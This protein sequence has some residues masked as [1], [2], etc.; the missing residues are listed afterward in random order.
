MKKLVTILLLIGFI[1]V[2]AGNRPVYAGEIDLLLQKLVEK[3][4]LT[5]GEAQQ[6][7]TETKE[8]IKAE[9]AQG[10]YSSL[11][12]WVQNMKMKGDFR[13]RYQLDHGKTSDA[14]VTS[15]RNRG[16][17]RLRLGW[18]TKVNDKIMVGAGIATGTTDYTSYD[19]ARS[20]NQ[21][22]EKGLAKKA[23]V[24]DY[25]YAKYSPFAWASLMGGK[26][27]YLPWRPTDVMIDN[28][29][30][31]EGA[32]LQLSKKLGKANLFLD[33]MAFVLT[34]TEP[35]THNAMVYGIQGG[36]D[37]ALTDNLSLKS[38]LS[39][40]DFS[41][42]KGRALDGSTG[43]NTRDPYQVPGSTAAK[44][45][46]YKYGYK[47][48][49]PAVELGIKNPLKAIANATGLSML[50]IE[51][52]SFFGEYYDNLAVHAKGT[53]FAGGFGFG[54]EKIDAWGKWQVQ[55]V[56]SMTEKDS[57]LDILPD[58]DRYVGTTGIRGHKGSFQ[59]GLGKN[60]WLQ[61]ALFRF[62]NINNSYS[63]FRRAPTTVMQVD[64]NMKF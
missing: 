44:S 3:G 61:C 31:P 17:V 24:L 18:D 5:A 43:T 47:I 38:A 8:Q 1:A 58:S 36:A 55:Y 40:Y 45:G 27:K 51:K 4:V 30:T 33:N 54:N 25:A 37:Y 9:I 20:N 11:P 19:A 52:L 60:T 12:E 48:V 63:T 26:M 53:G 57:I 29:I 42:V 10:K 28:D 35:T 56:Y 21:S 50:D 64:W 41:N 62:E 13:V 23:L 15:D 34:E 6:I 46:L 16:R 7:G 2:G 39:Y 59:W 22:F 32:V 14:G 49:T